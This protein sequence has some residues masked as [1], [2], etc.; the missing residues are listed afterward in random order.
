MQ[1]DRELWLIRHG[2]TEWSTRGAHTGS[3]D[4][5]LTQQGRQQAA[6]VGLQLEGKE[7]SHVLTSPRQ[8]AIE[9]CRL[10]GFGAVAEI[11]DA[12]QEWN[13]GPYEGK[14]TSEIRKDQ[15]DWSVWK[16]GV[17]GGETIDQVAARAAKVIEKCLR[18]AGP[19]LL[20]SHA[21]FLRVLTACWLGLEPQAGRLFRL[22]VAS[23]SVLG[24][25]RENRVI[26]HWNERAGQ[27]PHRRV[28]P[29][30]STRDRARPTQA[31]P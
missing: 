29:L 27:L 19:V 14:T 24:F 2:E 21:H 10:A 12:I 23:L 17:P 4:I 15:T 6:M 16:D 1:N 7:F 28:R 31:N 30:G 5:A 25:E 8:R 3:T 20:F 11:E 13:Y 22:D 26:R 9:T 18:F